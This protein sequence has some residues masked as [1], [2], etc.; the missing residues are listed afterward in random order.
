MEVMEDMVGLQC[1]LTT[2]RHYLIQ[3]QALPG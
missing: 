3:R 1:E 2:I